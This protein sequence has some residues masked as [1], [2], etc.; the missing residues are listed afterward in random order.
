M[1][2]ASKTFSSFCFSQSVSDYV[3]MNS[4]FR[5]HQTNESHEKLTIVDDIEANAKRPDEK[6]QTL[7]T[8]YAKEVKWSEEAEENRTR[9]S[10]VNGELVF[11][12]MHNYKWQ[13]R[14]VVIVF[15][16]FIQ[17]TVVFFSS[18]SCFFFSWRNV[19]T[20]VVYAFALQAHSNRRSDLY[21]FF[22]FLPFLFARSSL[23]LMS[24]EKNESSGNILHFKRKALHIGLVFFIH[25]WSEEEK[26]RN[27]R[28]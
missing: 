2:T 28:K 13:L 11:A 9:W 19:E 3:A 20:A 1:S 22:P 12:A 16:D 23:L 10:A 8:H 6:W 15:I 25:R 24:T 27:P 14:K 5:R 18:F 4:S 17:K 7:A 21:Y 26:K